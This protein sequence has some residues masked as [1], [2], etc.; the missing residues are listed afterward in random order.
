MFSEAQKRTILEE[1]GLKGWI[2]AN[3][4]KQCKTPE[5]LKKVISDKVAKELGD[6]PITIS[7]QYTTPSKPQ[8]R[9]EPI[10][11]L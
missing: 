7:L 9:W 11:T 2:L 4:I 10:D 1:Q 3:Q 5:E 8:A 6:L